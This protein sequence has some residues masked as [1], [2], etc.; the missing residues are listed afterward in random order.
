VIT[1]N[2]NVIAAEALLNPARRVRALANLHTAA[3]P[4]RWSCH[5]VPMIVSVSR[6]TT[7]RPARID[8]TA[9]ISTKV[10]RM[11]TAHPRFG[12]RVCASAAIGTAEHLG[13]GGVLVMPP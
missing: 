4:I 7:S 3:A 13:S 10:I 9:R 1:R 6:Q 8:N 5:G 11:V 2:C 12:E